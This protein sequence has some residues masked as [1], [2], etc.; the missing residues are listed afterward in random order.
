MRLSAPTSRSA[1]IPGSTPPQAAA[2]AQQPAAGSHGSLPTAR[3]YLDA[4][5]GDLSGVCGQL[6]ELATTWRR[7]H[8]SGTSRRQ[9][10]LAFPHRLQSAARQLAAT[11]QA[12][13]EAGAGPDPDLAS[14]AAA[15]L[16]ALQGGVAAAAGDRC[17]HQGESTRGRDPGTAALA[18]IEQTL[19][20]VVKRQQSLISHLADI[21][22]TEGPGP[23]PASTPA[24][25][26]GEPAA[27]TA[28]D[29]SPR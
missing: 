29:E 11:L 25:A 21:T 6:E 28:H 23:S 3:Q 12:L 27:R 2:A 26:P 9:L 24:D 17:G 19:N 8:T 10:P 7:D 15:Q 20:R 1:G 18:S 16:A 4:L 5:L 22:I 14:S 13:V